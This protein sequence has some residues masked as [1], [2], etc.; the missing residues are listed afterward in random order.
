MLDLLCINPGGREA[1]YQDLGAELTAVEPPLWCRL[2]AGYCR[3]RG[4]AVQILDAEAECLSARSIGLAVAGR[5]PRLVAMVVYGHQPS[6]STQQMAAASEACRMIKAFAPGAPVVIVGGHVAA[7]PERTMREEAVDFACNSEGPVTVERLL[8]HLKGEAG[9]RDVPGLVWGDGGQEVQANEPPA[10]LDMAELHGQVWDLLPMGR[11]RAHNW[12]GFG[13]PRGRVP[14]ASIHTSLGCPFKCSFCC[15]NAPFRSHRYRRRDPAAVVAEVAMLHARY[16]VR[17][18]KIVDEMFVLNERHY[19]AICEGLAALPF[20]GALNIWAYARVD[21]VKPGQLALLRRAGI[22]WLALGIESGSAHVRDGADKSLSDDDI[23]AVVASIQAAD[24][25]VIGNFIF[26]L[27]DDTRESMRATLDLALSLNCEFAN[28]YAAM[29]YPGSR[30]FDEA[31]AA[32]LP[33]RWSGY[34]QHSV[35]CTPLR[36][37]T[38]SAAEVLAFRDAAFREYFAAPGY[39]AMIERKFGAGTVAHIHEMTGRS[40]KRNLLAVA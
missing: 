15:I 31:D 21:T 28:F 8:A 12:Q 37:A 33:A 40:L 38:L 5:R 10:L 27:P 6:A 26:G 20:A 14:Y 19:A 2:I 3:D 29:A 36:T 18:F 25:N 35:D 9:L 22:R 23:R 39:L 1:I 7:L 24:I 11:Y 34:S 17:T 32:D 13:N 30:L 4:H 16:G